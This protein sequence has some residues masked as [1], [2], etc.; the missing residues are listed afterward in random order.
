VQPLIIVILLAGVVWVFTWYFRSYL[1]SRRAR[2]K[3]W[4]VAQ[5]AHQQALKAWRPYEDIPLDYEDMGTDGQY[6]HVWS[7]RLTPQNA[8]LPP[9]CLTIQ[10]DQVLGS[11]GSP[12]RLR[13]DGKPYIKYS[14]PEDYIWIIGRR[15]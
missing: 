4:D 15:T 8:S 2:Q 13:L 10:C 7:M 12:V 14:R 11:L 1:P 9:I 3:A 5:K 6:D